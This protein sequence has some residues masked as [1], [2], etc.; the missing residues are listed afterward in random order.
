MFGEAAS[1]SRSD[2]LAAIGEVAMSMHY[3]LAEPVSGRSVEEAVRLRKGVAAL[4]EYVR[5]KG[6][7]P[8]QEAA[9]AFHNVR[10][11]SPGD[12]EA[13]L[14][15]GLARELLEEHER[16]FNL[17][18]EV[19]RS[20]HD[21]VLRAR[22]AY[23]AAVSQLRRYSPSS[24]YEAES[25]L[26][27]LIAESDT[28]LAIR[29]FARATL[30]NEIAHKPIFW[31]DYITLWQ[32]TPKEL[33]DNWI[34][35]VNAV[36]TPLRQE[37]KDSK[38]LSD[39]EEIQLR[40]LCEN[41]LGNLLLYVGDFLVAAPPTYVATPEQIASTYAESETHYRNCEQLLPPGV[42]TYSNLATVL[43]RQKKY[44]AAIE[45]TQ[46][47]R[48]LNPRYEYAYYREAQ[49]IQQSSGDDACHRF[50]AIEAQE[51]EAIK[52]PSFRHLFENMHVQIPG[53]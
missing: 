34:A 18:D 36:L 39:K 27:Q 35:E 7:Q 42:E 44:Q 3:L 4:N 2:L 47:A 8:L 13:T 29:F 50:L 24:L 21:P 1:K 17:F 16:A 9:S 11:E 23:N 37:I 43:L 46:K 48:T 33:I 12:M 22:A 45:Y 28:P 51:L 53:G 31:K 6:F 41:A 26:H 10:L 38:I 25:I 5:S 49:A 20:A 15:E 30:A 32:R 19:R 52:I 40:W 14:Y